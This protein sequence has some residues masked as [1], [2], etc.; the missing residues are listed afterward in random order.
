[1]VFSVLLEA[2]PLF[3][4]VG[5]IGE[6]GQPPKKSRRPRVSRAKQRRRGA[7]TLRCGR[8]MASSFC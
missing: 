8:V 7:G 6:L 3:S 2:S 5:L 1:M 4:S